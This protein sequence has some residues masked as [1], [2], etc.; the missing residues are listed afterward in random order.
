M[1][2]KNAP[3]AFPTAG[4][5]EL[6]PA[7][8][9]GPVG[10]T[11]E[12]HVKPQD[13]MSLRDY[14]AAQALTGMLANQGDSVKDNDAIRAIAGFSYDLADAMLEARKNRGAE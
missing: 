14:F 10:A 11:I 1:T 12:H 6:R 13:G 3:A 8:N 9:M 4:Y 5:T 7:G 2:T